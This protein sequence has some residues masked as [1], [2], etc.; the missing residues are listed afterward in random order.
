MR[1]LLVG[2]PKQILVVDPLPEQEDE[3]EARPPPCAHGTFLLKLGW[4]VFAHSAVM[5]V[6]PAV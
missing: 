3:K 4:L 6:L 2:I 5:G 1:L